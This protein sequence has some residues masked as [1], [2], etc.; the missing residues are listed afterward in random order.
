MEFTNRRIMSPLKQ[1]FR[2]LHNT[3]KEPIKDEIRIT[4]QHQMEVMW[5]SYETKLLV[6]CEKKEKVL[7]K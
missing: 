5:Q 3:Q 2:E 4:L 1:I 7:L 6:A